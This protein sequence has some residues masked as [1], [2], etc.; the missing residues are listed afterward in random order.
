MKVRS[1]DIINALFAALGYRIEPI[2]TKNTQHTLASDPFLAQQGLIERLGCKSHVIFDVGA[3]KGDTAADYLSLFPDANIHCF[4]PF[5]E[6]LAQLNQRFASDERITIIPKAV[7]IGTGTTRFFVNHAAATNSLLPRPDESERFYPKTASPK[8]EI[9]VQTT[10]LD[11]YCRD[12]AIDHINVLKL[13][14]QGGELMALS[15]AESLL[16]DQRIDLVYSEIQFVPLYQ[17]AA[18][19]DGVWAKLRDTGYTLYDIYDLHRSA[20]GQLLYGDALFVSQ[21]CKQRVLDKL[22]VDG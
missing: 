2:R 5:P 16:K 17:N 22:K 9:E 15:G 1:K 6:T 12:N 19:F 18:Q 10:G 14:I 11:S 20:G 8:G 13:D 3:N 21:D 7:A 4:E